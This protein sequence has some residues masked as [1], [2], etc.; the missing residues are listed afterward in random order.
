M[1]HDPIKTSSPLEEKHMDENVQAVPPILFFSDE[2][3]DV[4]E[5]EPKTASSSGDSGPESQ[6]PD[7]PP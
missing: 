1:E 6:E 5:E 3:E 4:P 2:E 7:Q